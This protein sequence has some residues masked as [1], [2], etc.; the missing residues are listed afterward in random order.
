MRSEARPPRVVETLRRDIARLAAADLAGRLAGSTGARAAADWLQRELAAIGLQPAG[1]RGFKQPLSVPTTRL[2]GPARLIIGGRALQHRRDFAEL[3]THSGSGAARGPLRMLRAAEPLPETAV[4][5]ALLLLAD[6]P[7]D[8]DL[9]ATAQ[10]AAALGAQA[11]LIAED[12]PRWFAKS[13][14]PGNGPIPLLR[15]QRRLLPELAAKP[16]ADALLDLP[17]ERAARPCANLLARLPGCSATVAPVLVVA[18]YDHVGDD[19]GGLR[20]PGAFDNASGVALAL[21]LARKMAAPGECLPF[22]LVFTFTTGEESGLHGVR[23]LLAAD[24]RFAAAINLD[25]IGLAAR[26]PLL[27]TAPADIDDPWIAL[28]ER[29][30]RRTG[31]HPVRVSGR[32][33]ASALRAAGIATLGL[34]EQ[35]HV[36]DGDPMHTPDD[37][38][39]RV[40][41]T[42]LLQTLQA[43]ADLLTDPA[44]P[45][46]LSPRGATPWTPPSPVCCN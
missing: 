28:A 45:R 6:P 2:L 25:A 40:H 27:R 7:P 24:T 29:A 1:S 37:L 34:G 42:A 20:H 39:Q 5:G 8:L 11:L 36:E 9:A 17:L 21:A 12:A 22:D 14:H 33:D 13:V 10:A 15:V 43:L 35:Y 16:L 23:A 41:A 3:S 38:P 44:L 4:A 31:I 30:L 46:A 26:D 18:H 19:P 32:D